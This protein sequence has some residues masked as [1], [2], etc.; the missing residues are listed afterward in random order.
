MTLQEWRSNARGEWY[1]LAQAILMALVIFAPKELP[2]L[3]RWSQPAAGATF[4]IGALLVALG[5]LL[6]AASSFRLGHSLSPFPRPK[7]DAALAETGPYAIVR[8]PIYSGFT[9]AAFGW[10]LAWASSAALVYAVA[11]FVF[12]DIK[13]R[14]EEDWLRRKFA[15][16]EQ[17]RRRVKKL[18]P[19]IY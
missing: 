5:L 17:Y 1:V 11:L 18:V 12:F 14:R 19:L 9:L 10:A 13:S 3:P 16:Y 8:H 4:I 15:H 2:G 7:D 6:T